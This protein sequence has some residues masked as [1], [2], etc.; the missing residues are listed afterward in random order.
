MAI[1]RLRALFWSHL[2]KTKSHTI[3]KSVIVSQVHKMCLNCTKNAQD[4][5]AAEN[6]TTD[7]SWKCTGAFCHT[8]GEKGHHYSSVKLWQ[9]TSVLS[10]G[11]KSLE[12]AEIFLNQGEEACHLY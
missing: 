11:A 3:A 2:P 1:V 5:N 8:E 6:E 4:H 9:V 12:H 10:A 7:G